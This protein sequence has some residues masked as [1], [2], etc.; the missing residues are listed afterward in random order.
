LDSNRKYINK[1]GIYKADVV[2]VPLEDGDRTEALIKNK[3]K[4]IVI[5][6]NP[7]SRSAQKANIAIVDNITRAVPLLIMTIKKLKKYNLSRNQ[8]EVIYGHHD[9]RKR[10]K[11]SLKE[12]NR[13]NVSL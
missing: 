3:K 12:I 11:E 4:V 2:F 1:N 6:L 5:D 10:L 13:Q 7:L 9:N 8:L